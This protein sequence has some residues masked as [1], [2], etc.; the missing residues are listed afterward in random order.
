MK[1]P[2]LLKEMPFKQGNSFITAALERWLGPGSCVKSLIGM[3]EEAHADY[4]VQHGH[5]MQPRGWLPNKA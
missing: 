4:S 5:E 3:L 2:D 1:P